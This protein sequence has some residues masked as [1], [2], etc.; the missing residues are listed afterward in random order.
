MRL[1]LRQLQIFR[2]VAETGSTV[3]AADRVALSQSA[4]SVALAE[5]ERALDAR[6][7]DRIGRR[8]LLNDRGRAL[9][10]AAVALLDDARDIEAAFGGAGR[11][12]LRLAASTTIG[13]YVLPGLLAGF[14]AQWPEARLGLRVGNTLEVV[15]AVTAFE[16]DL[17]F[18]EGPCHAD[19]VTVIP[20]R[21][22]E[23]VVIAAPSHPLA[24]SAAQGRLPLRRL[25]EVRWLLREPGSG[26]R[27]AVEQAL[28]PHLDH[29]PADMTL[30]SSEAIKNAVA[31]GLGV[32][33]LS[34]SVVRDLLD[35][36]RLVVLPTTLPRLSRPFSFV[37]HEKKRLSE[38]LQA[39]LAHCIG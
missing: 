18:I 9:L 36:G 5:L 24:R 27:E 13:N 11:P 39:F 15:N 26:T 7:F 30:G 37:H 16:V 25:R 28:L 23:L 22:D 34:R 10:P 14:R 32:S 29:L 8:L 3:A 31:E 33:C 12:D 2:A 1:T 38:A 35:L 6:L 4:T 20:W 17:G 19:A 21:Q